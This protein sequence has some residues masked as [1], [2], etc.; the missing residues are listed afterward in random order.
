[1]VVSVL[2]FLVMRFFSSGNM[3]YDY[4]PRFPNCLK[5]KQFCF[6]DIEQCFRNK[7]NSSVATEAQITAAIDIPDLHLQDTHQTFTK[8]WSTETASFLSIENDTFCFSQLGSRS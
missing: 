7:F 2:R 6:S 8:T 5:N 3:Y 4:T 1:M